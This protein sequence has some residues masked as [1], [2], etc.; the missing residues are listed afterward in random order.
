MIG[1]GL[2]SVFLPWIGW[3]L[4]S[5]GANTSVSHRTRPVAV[6]R[7][8]VRSEGAAPGPETLVVR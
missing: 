2:A 8:T 6:S 7:Q 1:V 5:R 4:V 3:F